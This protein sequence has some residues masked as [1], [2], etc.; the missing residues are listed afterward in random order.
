MGRLPHGFWS[1]ICINTVKSTSRTPKSCFFPSG[2]SNYAVDHSYSPMVVSCISSIR[3][4]SLD[5]LVLHSTSYKGH[6]T[7]CHRSTNIRKNIL[8]SI[9]HSV[10]LTIYSDEE[11]YRRPSQIPNTRQNNTTKFSISRRL[12]QCYYATILQ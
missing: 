11:H 4:S 8:F 3:F 1:T 7:I 2:H 5:G 9:N 10:Q 12:N 6:S